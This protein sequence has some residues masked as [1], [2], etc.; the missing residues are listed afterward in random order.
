MHVEQRH[1][2]PDAPG[3]IAAP[4]SVLAISFLAL[5]VAAV[6]AFVWPESLSDYSAL[7][8][9]LALIPCFL[10]AYHKGWRGAATA[11]AAAMLLLVAVEVGLVA[12]FG[13]TDQIDWRVFA[14][15][16][17][18]LITVSLGVG[19]VSEFHLRDTMSASVLAYTDALTGIPNRRVLDEFMVRYF[20]AAERGRALTVVMFDVDG[21]KRYNDR[22]GHAA[23]DDALRAVSRIME[24]NTRGMDLTGRFGGEE[25]V[26]L[27]PGSLSIEAKI[28]AERV[29]EEI[30]GSRDFH[31]KGLT[32]SAGIAQ[33]V[34]TMGTST[35]LLEAADA[36]LYAAKEAGKNTVVVASPGEA[37][38]PAGTAG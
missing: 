13:S 11:S 33:Y 22:F 37:A 28:F 18:L 19:I 38:V 4:P 31:G 8:W 23:G 3:P 36:A 9:L 12:I 26:T 30:E 7:V 14:T 17:I 6:A 32:L 34:P 35:D 5:G 1:P 25:F 10:L 27:L 2:P 15:V 20:A 16:S 29:R 24:R 21:F